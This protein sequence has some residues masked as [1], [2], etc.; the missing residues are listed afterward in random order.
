GVNGTGYYISK[1]GTVI[2]V[3]APGG[4][5][6]EVI[7]TGGSGSGTVAGLTFTPNM[8]KRN[9]AGPFASGVTVQGSQDSSVFVGDALTFPRGAQING[10]FYSNFD[11]GQGSLTF[12]W[13]PEFSS[14]TY[15]TGS[16][17]SYMI[18]SS[19]I[20]MRYEYSYSGA[21][22]NR[23]RIGFY[24]NS[25]VQSYTI[26]AG[27]T[28]QITLRWDEDNTFDGSKYMI[29]SVND[30]HY[31]IGTSINPSTPM[32]D[33]KI[34]FNG[35]NTTS[36]EAIIEGLTVYRRPL[37]DGTYGIDVGNGDEIAQIYN[38]GTGKD[39]TLVT[40]SWDVV[41]A[42]PTNAS[43]GTIASGTGNAWSHPHASNLLY[44]ST[45]NTGGF[46][47]NGTPATDGWS[48]IP[49]YKV[50]G[51]SGVVAAYQPIGATDLANSYVNKANPGT[52]NAS[53]GVAPTWDAA[54]GWIFNGTTQYLQNGIVPQ[55]NQT[56]SVVAKMTGSVDIYG[57]RWSF[58]V[59]GPSGGLEYI[60]NSGCGT[61]YYANGS[62]VG[63]VGGMIPFPGNTVV[64]IAAQNLY[65]N[66]T[67]IKDVTVS[68]ATLNTYAFFIG[69]VNVWNA[70]YMGWSNAPAFGG[71]PQSYQALAIYNSTLTSTQVSNISNAM[72]GLS[73]LGTYI[74]ASALS[75]SEKIFSGGY[76]YTSNGGNQGIYRSF[77][78]T[79]GGDYVLR[80]LGHSD[81]TCSPKIQITRA[82]GTTTLTTLSGTTTS[83]RTDPDVYI[84]TWESP[85]AESEQVQL[86]NTASTGTCYWHQVE[87]LGNLITNP[88]METGSGNPWYPTGWAGGY[89]P[90]LTGQLMQETGDKRSGFSSLKYV[91]SGD[92]KIFVSSVAL[93]QTGS[94]Y[95]FGAFYK[96]TGGNN[97]IQ[98]APNYSGYLKDALGQAISNALLGSNTVWV[99]GKGVGRLSAAENSIFMRTTYSSGIVDDNYMFLNNN[100]S[101]TV[102]PANL[103][104]STEASGLRIDGGD[105]Y[106]KGIS[107]IVKGKGII[108]MDITPRHSFSV[109]DKFGFTKPVIA[110]LYIDANNSL[111][112]YKES[113]TVLRLTGVW[114][115]VIVNGDWT[116]PTLN[117]GTKYNIEINYDSN[118]SMKL[119]VD[120]TE[121]I[122][123]ALSGKK[124]GVDP[125]GL[126]YIGSD[127]TGSNQYD[128]N[129]DTGTIVFKLI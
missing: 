31:L 56:W 25:F 30:T 111:K 65:Y 47:M 58:G 80:A 107:T 61:S 3:V 81:G 8:S 104:N 121:R 76:K 124:F 46:M 91:A 36:S 9:S 101:L 42:L 11:R 17:H 16:I 102:T 67:L 118:G 20:Y 108:E 66:G 103:A 86:I 28:Y 129:V 72:S 29:L 113:A 10:N 21:V 5:L 75:P 94:F 26:N 35:T 7:E 90:P 2:K 84:F 96:G 51:A 82:D 59:R 98:W 106:T 22:A 60:S 55:F 44:T 18:D 112:L 115:G 4:Q 128:M 50:G 74:T 13:T 117:A 71:Q 105:T 27:T 12:F 53:P 114:N 41:F 92:S 57:T 64:G 19:V 109:A 83:T 49:W 48:E 45:T 43:T 52:Y 34:G 123:V 1:I 32:T 95:T 40:G 24:G 15:S 23:F 63:C 37:F 126:L 116:N 88:S 70:G 122:S 120:N 99:H 100:V 89:D 125:A 54:N 6:G 62:S 78:A 87:V 93:N 73:S 97:T 38:S 85:A 77:T 33:I 69:A 14:G 110:H 68:N 127:N 79:A 119:L 39:P